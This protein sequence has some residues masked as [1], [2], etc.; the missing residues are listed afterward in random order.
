MRLADSPIIV[1]LGLGF[2]VLDCVLSAGL[3]TWLWARDYVSLDQNC[4]PSELDWACGHL[5]T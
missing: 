1:L 5:E 4:R 2:P 3:G